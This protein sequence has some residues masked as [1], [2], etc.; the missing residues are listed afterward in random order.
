MATDNGTGNG[1]ERNAQLFEEALDKITEK[2]S[3]T[4]EQAFTSINNELKLNYSYDFVDKNRETLNEAIMKGIKKGAPAE[5]RLAAD[6]LSLI[7]M[8]LGLDSETLFKDAVPSL[9]EL[10]THSTSDDVRISFMDC[11]AFGA[12]INSDEITTIEYMKILS[13]V[14]NDD[15]NSALVKSGAI[16]AWNLLLTTVSKKFAYDTLIPDHLGQIVELLKD[17]SVDL[18]VEAGEAVALLFEVARDIEADSFEM[19]NLS[20]YADLDDLLELLYS[21]AHDKNK[22]RSRKDKIK[23]RLP[24]KEIKTFV[25]EG[26][27]P[28]EEIEIKFTKIKFSAWSQIKQLDAVRDVLS[29]GFQVHFQHNEL[30]QDMFDVVISS[31]KKKTTMNAIEKRMLL[32]PNSPMNKLKTKNLSKQRMIR[33]RAT[34]SFLAE[35]D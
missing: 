11:F 34:E 2:R 3:A 24:F 33:E 28:E 16:S 30:L 27:I 8:T 31:E 15:K 14:F 9:Q 35:E 22:T 29:V 10:I 25:E 32:S 26:V 7:C 17:E 12:F 18:R 5:Q 20:A 1:A 19:E 13:S 6:T 23:Q 4:R 21:L